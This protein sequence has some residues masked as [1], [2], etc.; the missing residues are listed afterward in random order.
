M[1]IHGGRLGAGR[2][3]RQASH[4]WLARM[5]GKLNPDSSITPESLNLG[6]I[7][8]LFLDIRDNICQLSI[9]VRV[10]SGEKV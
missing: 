8:L 6:K 10:R 3:C 1:L 7:K 9:M 2:V 5:S 4:G